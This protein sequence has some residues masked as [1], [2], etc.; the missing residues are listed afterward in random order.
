MPQGEHSVLQSELLSRIN[1]VG[2]PAKIAY[3]FPELRCN[4][5]DVS[6]VP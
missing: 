2:N 5:A 3:A 6:I 1:Q 4:F